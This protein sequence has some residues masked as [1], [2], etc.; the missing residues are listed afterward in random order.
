VSRYGRVYRL[1]ELPVGSMFER[2]DDGVIVRG[3][4]GDEGVDGIQ[5]V[6]ENGD[7]RGHRQ[8]WYA[9]TLVRKI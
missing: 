8:A 2:K 6:L 3:I 5:V 9:G 1:D 4:V 7:I